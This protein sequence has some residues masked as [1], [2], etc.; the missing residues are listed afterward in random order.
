MKENIKAQEKKV[1]G[2][3][4]LIPR[5]WKIAREIFQ[6]NWRISLGEYWILILLTCLI[7]W[8]ANLIGWEDSSYS[9]YGILV[10]I[11][12]F[13]IILNLSIKRSNDLN[14]SQ[15]SAFST[16]IMLMIFLLLFKYTGFLFIWFYYLFLY[17]L[18]V[19][20]YFWFAIRIMILIVSI[21]ALYTFSRW[22]FELLF[23]KWWT[24]NNQYGGNPLIDQSD[25]NSIYRVVWIIL[26]LINIIILL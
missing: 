8:Y 3:E 20:G 22:G 4:Q 11:C 25:S 17:I 10:N 1:Y 16:A 2:P 13:I 6:R 14:K 23:K 19:F 21:R 7:A 9:M 24:W 12:Q 18:Y 26:L 15:K 5:I